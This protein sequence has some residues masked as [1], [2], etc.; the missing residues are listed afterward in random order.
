MIVRDYVVFDGHLSQKGPSQA[1]LHRE[2]TLFYQFIYF[3][4][5]NFIS[6]SLTLI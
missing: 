5:E 4:V 1:G 3:Y 2:Q 6:S